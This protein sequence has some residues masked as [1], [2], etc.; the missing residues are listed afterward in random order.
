MEHWSFRRGFAVAQPFSSWVN[1]YCRVVRTASKSALFAGL[2]ATMALP[3]A[4][5]EDTTEQQILTRSRL[6]GDWNGTRSTLAQK[7]ISLEFEYTSTYQGL[8]TGANAGKFGYGGKVDLYLNLDTQ[9]LFRWPGGQLVGHFEFR[10]GAARATLGGA[11]LPV[12]TAQVVPLGTPSQIVATSLY[13]RQSLSEKVSLLIGKINVL[14]LLA[15]DPFFGGGG[16]RRFMNVAFVAPPSGVLPPVIFGAIANVQ[17]APISWTA[18]V[19]DP[20]D[21]TGEYLPG[22][23]F[24]DGVNVSLSGTYSGLVA[25]RGTKFTLGA[26]YSTKEG[27]DLS[28]VG[29]PPDLR[30]TKIKGSYNVSFQ[31]SHFLQEDPAGGG[32]WGVFLKVGLSDGNPNTFKGFVTGG[33]GGKA[34]MFGRPQDNFG[35]GVFNYAFSDELKSALDPT[36]NFDDERGIEI[37]YSRAITPWFHLTGDI[38]YIDPATG[39]AGKG[40]ILGLRSNIRF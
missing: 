10:N 2:I 25:G 19:Y 20:N 35:I 38:Q 36:L 3:V 29:L 5:G 17:T 15:N 30:T 14:D 12:N 24:S 28:E 4:G 40:L 16:N 22:D 39:D 26:I 34:L 23:L 31:L 32:G 27:G 11:V 18:M 9:K 7:G 21:R 33:I 1:G 8:A 13:L 6:T 37:F